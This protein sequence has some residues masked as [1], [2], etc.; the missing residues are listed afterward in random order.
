M[1]K[2]GFD[3]PELK[4]IK[5]DIIVVSIPSLGKGPHEKW[6]TWG[7]NLLSMSGFTYQWAHPERHRNRKNGKRFPWRLCGWRKNRRSNCRRTIFPCSDLARGNS[8]KSLKLSQLS[9]CWDPLILDYFVN[10]HIS[11]PVGNR[12]PSFA[13]YNSYRCDGKDNWCVIAVSD[14]EGWQNLRKVMDDPTSAR[15]Q[16]PGYGKPA[17]KCGR[18]RPEY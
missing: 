9:R 2:W 1:Q 8:S 15:I 7:M 11:P 14:E 18:A 3:Y 4:K 12:H 5:E 16:I 6:T 10:G 13:P 17:E